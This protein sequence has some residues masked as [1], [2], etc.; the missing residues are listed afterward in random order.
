MDRQE[1]AYFFKVKFPAFES[2]EPQVKNY[3]NFIKE[4]ILRSLDNKEN[5]KCK[6]Y[7]DAIAIE[8]PNYNTTVELKKTIR[9]FIDQTDRFYQGVIVKN[10][11]AA[12]ATMVFNKN[13][14]LPALSFSDAK[15]RER[16]N[17]KNLTLTHGNNNDLC[18]FIET[19]ALTFPGVVKYKRAAATGS[20]TTSHKLEF[21]D[22]DIGCLFKGQLESYALYG[23]KNF[24]YEDIEVEFE[25][26]ERAKQQIRS[27]EVNIE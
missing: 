7:N 26:I 10:N 22:M 20:E 4:Q 11:T 6:V 2:N 5:V 18:T 25:V 13:P 8:T 24:K 9:H 1:E 17:Y 21:Q 16:G 27:I 12:F 14:A 19:M 23:K 3:N 15:P